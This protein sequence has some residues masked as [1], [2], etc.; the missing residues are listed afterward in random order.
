MAAEW[1]PFRNCE[2][3]CPTSLPNLF[4]LP[5]SLRKIHPPPH[6]ST[7]VLRLS[8]TF[9]SP[10]PPR[11]LS[12]APY[13]KV[14]CS[15]RILISSKVL[16]PLNRAATRNNALY[17]RVFLLAFLS[18]IVVGFS[19]FFFFFLFFFLLL[20]FSASFCFFERILF[21]PLFF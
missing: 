12:L 19:S 7:L 16:F 15:S 8:T 11:V 14:A 18:S 21:S 10:F 13:P 17:V 4:L 3:P 9:H 5:P 1:N 20:S 2:P 6:S